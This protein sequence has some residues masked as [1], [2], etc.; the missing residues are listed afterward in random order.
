MSE[1]KEKEETSQ[2][3]TTT[4]TE[5]INEAPNPTLRLCLNKKATSSG[6]SVKWRENT[7]DNEFMNRKKSKCCCVYKKPL[8]WDESSGEDENDEE[9]EHC[10][11]H[12]KSDYN[13]K[14]DKDQADHHDHDHGELC[15]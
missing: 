11:G 10:K 4:V 9:C 7:V 14:R 6:K 1:T 13:S 5:T 8:R 3:T 2:T 15:H 12:K